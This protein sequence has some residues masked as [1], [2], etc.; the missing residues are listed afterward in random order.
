[1]QQVAP[2][3]KLFNKRRYLFY[4]GYVTKKEAQAVAKQRRSWG[5]RVRLVVISGIRGHF[6]YESG[7]IDV[8][9]KYPGR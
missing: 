5:L 4:E 1:M 7:L 3:S 2:N 6:L 8:K 9:K